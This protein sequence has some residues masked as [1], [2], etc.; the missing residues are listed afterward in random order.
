MQANILNEGVELMLYGMGTVFV[1]LAVLVVVTTAMSAIVQRFFPDAPEPALTNT[2]RPAA[3][4]ASNDDQLL[5][6]ITAAVHKY[7]SRK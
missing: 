7:R 5:A 6:V 1:F 4:A 3:P 2:P